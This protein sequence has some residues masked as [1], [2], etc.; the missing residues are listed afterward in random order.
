MP[1]FDDVE[2]FRDGVG[3]VFRVSA[4]VVPSGTNKESSITGNS[5]GRDGVAAFGVGVAFGWKKLDMDACFLIWE[6]CGGC[7]FF[8]GAIVIEG[9]LQQAQWQ[10]CAIVLKVEIIDV[11][12][13]Q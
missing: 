5:D 10:L 1:R 13:T 12:V 7:E 9:Q 3:E 2:V 4:G 6:D 8:G 11:K